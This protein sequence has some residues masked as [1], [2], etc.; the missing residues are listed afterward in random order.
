MNILL[1]YPTRARPQLFMD[2]VTLWNG[3]A[4]GFNR[5]DWLVSADADD[6]TMNCE[7]IRAWCQERSIAIH[8][9][10]SKSKVEACNADLHRAPADWEVLV[11]VSDDMIPSQGWDQAIR[12]NMPDDLNAGLWFPDG[13]QRR[14]CTLSIFGRPILDNVLG[15][16]VCH[17]EF[18]SVY[19]DNYYHWLMESRGLL[20][21]VDLPTFRHAWKERNDDAL[22]RRNENRQGY[23]DDRRTFIKLKGEHVLT[24]Q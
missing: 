15:G 12:E 16:W 18:K 9:G 17:P 1:K 2:A 6:E 23:R 13:R 7:R 20:K 11:L 5:V 21:F 22:M 14:T 3:T 19:C 24:E 4:S 10:N 8:Y